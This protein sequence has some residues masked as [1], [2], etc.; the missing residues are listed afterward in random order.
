MGLRGPAPEPIQFRKRKG[1]PDG[2]KLPQEPRVVRGIPDAPLGLSEVAARKWGELAPTLHAMGVLSKQ[3]LHA[4]EVGC[5]SYAEWHACRAKLREYGGTSYEAETQ[6][7]SVIHKAYPE[8]AERD[9][10][11]RRYM[12]FLVQYGL[13]ASARARVAPLTEGSSDAE[14]DFA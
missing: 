5:E 1:N 9:A 6:N 14:K 3:D 12:Q 8:V 11:W 7:G 4:L 10:A 2:H 13:T